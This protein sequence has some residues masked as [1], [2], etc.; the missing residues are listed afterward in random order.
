MNGFLL[1]FDSW[2]YCDLRLHEVFFLFCEMWKGHL[3]VFEKGTTCCLKNKGC[4]LYLHI[5]NQSKLMHATVK[6]YST[7]WFSEIYRWFCLHTV[8]K[9]LRLKW[10]YPA[11]RSSLLRSSWISQEE[12]GTSADI[13]YNS[14]WACSKF[15]FFCNVNQT[16]TVASTVFV[17]KF[18]W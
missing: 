17:S 16:V 9:L 2:F 7:D 18:K 3:S 1:H 8:T 13:L 4:Y 10:R 15:K 14:Y 6:F 11:N 5:Q 12:E